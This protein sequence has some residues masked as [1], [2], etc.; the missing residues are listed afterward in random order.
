MK[1][2]NILV[3]KDKNEVID[4]TNT[5][6]WMIIKAVAERTGIT[7]KDPRKDCKNCYGRGYIGFNSK[8]KEPVPC[9]CIFTAEQ[10]EKDRPFKMNRAQKRKME[11]KFRVMKRKGLLKIKQGED[12]E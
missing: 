7:V 8:S 1:M 9:S 2:L 3:D 6:P 4:N 11:K 10:K 12:N 5:T